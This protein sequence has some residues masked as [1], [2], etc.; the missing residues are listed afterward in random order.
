[1]NSYSITRTIQPYQTYPNPSEKKKKKMKEEEESMVAPLSFFHSL[2]K[3][4]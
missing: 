2:T 1:M 4:T 3:K